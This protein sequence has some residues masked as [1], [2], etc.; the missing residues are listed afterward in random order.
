MLLNVYFVNVS[1]YMNLCISTNLCQSS[2]FIWY[3]TQFIYW[4]CLEM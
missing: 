4:S 3:E 2:S 1:K